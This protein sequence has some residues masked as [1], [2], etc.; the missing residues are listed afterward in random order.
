MNFLKKHFLKILL[1]I[2]IIYVASIFISQQKMINAYS[3]E[4]KNYESKIE[5]EKNTNKELLAMKENLDST[6]YIE[7]IAR[8]KLDMYLP[9]ERV[10]IDIAK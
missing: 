7:K 6:E 4:V 10:Y 9:N 1:L 5:D 8:D 3:L 2:V